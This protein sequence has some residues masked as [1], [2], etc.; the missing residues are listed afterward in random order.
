M[1]YYDKYLKYKNKYL[2][3]KNQL[4][5]DSINIGGKDYETNKEYFIAAESGSNPNNYPRLTDFSTAEIS[6]VNGLSAKYPDYYFK[7]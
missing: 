1:S 2:G 7:F 4:G 5:G 3:L 6:T